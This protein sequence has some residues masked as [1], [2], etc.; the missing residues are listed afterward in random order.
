[1]TLRTLIKPGISGWAQINEK[2][3]DTIEEAKERLAY[4][5]F[6]L[7]NRNLVLD[8]IIILKTL[9]VFLTFWGK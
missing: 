2:T 1:Y 4:D 7:K 8:F 9:R 6:Y 5:L 3:G